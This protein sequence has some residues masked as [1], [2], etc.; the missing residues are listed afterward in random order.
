MYN[1]G[2]EIYKVDGI[3]L[4][5]GV[6]SDSQELGNALSRGEHTSVSDVWEDERIEQT[7]VIVMF[8]EGN[9][10]SSYTKEL[11]FLDSEVLNLAQIQLSQ[12][13]VKVWQEVRDCMGQL[14]L[15]QGAYYHICE[16][17]RHV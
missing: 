5:R 14:R 15:S 8:G 4:H 12:V 16:D 13:S 3:Y 17:N 2:G 10:K 1:E 6:Q 7:L 9:A 11:F